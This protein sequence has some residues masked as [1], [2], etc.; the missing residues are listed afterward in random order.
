MEFEREATRDVA[1]NIKVLG[2]G[3]GGV[4]AVNR[5]IASGVKGVEFI[6]INTDKQSLERSLAETKLVIGEKINNGFGAGSNPEIGK[7][8]AEEALNEIR[9]LIRGADMVF[10]TAGM[11]GGTGTYMP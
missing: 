8:A 6:A 2:V 11:G 1:V 10:V 9:Q 5:M 7:R 3:G 4:N